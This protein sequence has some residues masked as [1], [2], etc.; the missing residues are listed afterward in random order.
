MFQELVSTNGPLKDAEL[1]AFVHEA[2]GEEKV[3]G[4]RVLCVIPDGTRSMPMPAMFRA[5]CASLL[6][7]VAQLDMII[8]LG[9]HPPMSDDEI[10]ELVGIT[11]E[12]RATTYS[13]V[14]IHNH[15]WDNPDALTQIGVI[16]KDEMNEIT[17]GV[18]VDEVAVNINKRV[19]DCDV[20]LIVGPVFP[21]EIVGMSGGN[22]YFFPGIGGREILDFFHWLGALITNPKIIGVK[23]T[24]VRAVVDRAAS[25]IPVEKRAFCVNVK[26]K[27]CG[28]V[29]FGTPEDAWSAA[30][31]LAAKTHIK[32]HDAPYESVL[33]LCPEMYYELWVAG[34]CMYKLEPVVADG[35]ELIIYGPHITDISVTHGEILKRIGYHTRDYFTAN[36]DKFADVPGGVMT[37]S[38]LVRGIGTYVDGVEKPRVQV[39][40]AT[41]L[42][43]ETCHALNLGYRDPA[44]INPEDWENAP[45]R[46]LVPKA[47]EILHRLKA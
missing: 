17:G 2:L 13:A 39:T 47:G 16:S 19:L 10:N 38:T 11:A 37:H 32:Y 35:G 5:V 1:E 33:T 8:A 12:E 44:T 24:P 29:F 6:P 28:G 18:L 43:E 45:G 41:S 31:D 20:A 3:D 27:E 15:E 4:K 42:S 30:A 46:L 22:K 34:K 7:R 40:L 21:H 23:H 14:A 9:T 25:F 36:M 26:S